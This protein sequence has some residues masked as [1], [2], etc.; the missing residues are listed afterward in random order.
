MLSLLLLQGCCSPF[1]KNCAQ[2]FTSSSESWLLSVHLFGFQE[3]LL[4]LIEFLLL[5]PNCLRCDW[6]KINRGIKLNSLIISPLFPRDLQAH[7][8]WPVPHSKGDKYLAGRWSLN[9]ELVCFV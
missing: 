3:I 8:P 5:L 9:Q 2:H 6:E 4:Y 7:C 1:V